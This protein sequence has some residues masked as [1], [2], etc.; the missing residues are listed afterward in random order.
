MTAALSLPRRLRGRLSAAAEAQYQERRRAFCAAIL[1]IRARLD[2]AISARGWCYLLEEYGLNKGDFDAAEALINDC[3]K[4]GELP[5]DIA[6]EDG[7]RRFS[8]V[9]T[10]DTETPEESASGVLAYVQ[11]AHVHYQPISFWTYQSCYVE[12]LVEKIDLKSLFEPICAEY[13]VP[14]ANARGSADINSRAAMMR[15]FAG[16]EMEGRQCVLLYAGDFDPAGLRISDFLHKNLADLSQAVGW[17][18]DSLIIDRFGLNADF[19]RDHGLTW[20][21]NLETGSGGRLDD[22][23]HPDH[24][25]AYVHDY[26]AEFGARKVEANAL[27]TRATAGRELCR[28]AILKYIDDG[29]AVADFEAATAIK[30]SEMQ[31]EVAK[32]LLQHIGG[33]S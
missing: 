32:L 14:I 1:E 2:F 30:Q 5:L 18:P 6:A 21:N 27:V 23:R 16:H 25:K 9:E 4:T 13:R 7:A 11:C 29:E 26:L 10:P 22:P 17:R 19:I 31:T 28:R 24:G 20:I 8:N 3:R 33:A 12:M 15:R